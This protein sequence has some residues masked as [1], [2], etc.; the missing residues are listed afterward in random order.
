MPIYAYQCQACGHGFEVMQKM[1]DPAPS[2][3]PTCGQGEVRKQLSA[4]GFQLKGRGWYATDFKG[5]AKKDEPKDKVD[6]DPKTGS[7][8][9]GGCGSCGA[10]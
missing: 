9:N 10:H 4:A 3:C 5:G 1:S 2:A 8:G 6:S 7:C